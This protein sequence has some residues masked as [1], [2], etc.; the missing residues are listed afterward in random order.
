M[1]S[2]IAWEE[3]LSPINDDDTH[4]RTERYEADDV[5]VC[6]VS[7]AWPSVDRS[8]AVRP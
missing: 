2:G 5:E 7:R 3:Q 8:C 4:Y 6:R 1:T